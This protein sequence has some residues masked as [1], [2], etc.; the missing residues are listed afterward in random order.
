MSSIEYGPIQ[1][2]QT[3]QVS[4]WPAQAQPYPYPP[5]TAAQPGPFQPVYQQPVIT[6]VPVLMQ[7]APPKEKLTTGGT[8]GVVLGSILGWLFLIFN[9]LLFLVYGFL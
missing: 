8:V 7:P 2:A 4:A 9:V 6:M 5:P 3:P 1:Q